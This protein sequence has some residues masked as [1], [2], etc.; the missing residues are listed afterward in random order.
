MK[1]MLLIKLKKILDNTNSYAK[2]KGTVK[3]LNSW[4]V[5]F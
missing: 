2:R 4:R 3:S 1:V 5:I